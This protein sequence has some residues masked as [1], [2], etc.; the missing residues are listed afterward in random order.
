MKKLLLV[1]VGPTAVGKTE[2]AINLAKY[3]NTEIVSAD[4]RQFYRELNVGTSK[5]S[6][7]ELKRIPHHFINSHSILEEFNV[8]DFEKSV[9]DLLY[10][11][12]RQ[13][14]VLIMVGGS[15]LYCKSVW[16]GLDELPIID[17]NLR[18]VINE[19]VLQNG[20]DLLLVE[21]S[22]NDPVYF[23]QV[24]QQNPM[25]VKRAIEVIRSTGKPFSSFI[26]KTKM[27]RTFKNFKE[28][29]CKESNSF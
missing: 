3:F 19:E 25:R 12:F 7:E 18:N 1:I 15:G 10:E 6:P 5:P 9:L 27:P 28:A 29:F 22:K 2:L 8:R 14:N 11:L 17:T 4:S 20:L 23:N 24:D 16:E 26:G 13:Y 21:L